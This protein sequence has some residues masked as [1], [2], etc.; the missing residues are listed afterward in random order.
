MSFWQERKLNYSR[1][2]VDLI[3]GQGGSCCGKEPGEVGD[4]PETSGCAL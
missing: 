2:D 1:V 4:L 3:A